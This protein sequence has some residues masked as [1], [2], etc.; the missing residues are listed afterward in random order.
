LSEFLKS[1]V[2]AEIDP[3]SFWKE[4][5]GRFSNLSGIALEYLAVHPQSDFF[6]AVAFLAKAKKQTCHQFY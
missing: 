2:D 3:L 5:S 4:K 1:E 6:L